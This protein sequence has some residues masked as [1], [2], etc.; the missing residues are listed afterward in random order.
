[1]CLKLFTIARPDVAYFGRKDAQQVAVVKQVV[2]DLN[3]EL[4]VRVV[5]TV[6]DTDGLALSSRNGR[7]SPA[8]RRRALAIPRALAT[9]DPARARAV[10]AEAGI[11]PEY[12]AVANLDGPTLA[13]AARVGSTR[14]IDNVLLEGDEE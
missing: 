8:E 11:E 10:L 2:R 5:P 7:L 6:R 4:E 1:V 12:L 3:L 13:V 14:L 9:G